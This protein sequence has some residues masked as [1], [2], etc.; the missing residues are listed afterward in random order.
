MEEKTLKIA[1]TPEQKEQLQKATGKEVPAVKLRLEPLEL[2]ETP[3]I[4]L[5]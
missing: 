1:L 3:A 4:T 5:N 2:R